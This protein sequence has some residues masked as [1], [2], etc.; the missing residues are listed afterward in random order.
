MAK[1]IG[2]IGESGSGKTTSMEG[3]DPKTTIYIDADKKG[4]SWKGWRKQYNSEAKNY[5]KT[6]IPQVIMTALWKING[7]KHPEDP[8][9]ECEPM[10]GVKTVVIDTMKD[11]GNLRATGIISPIRVGKK[12]RPSPSSASAP[13]RIWNLERSVGDFTISTVN[14]SAS[15]LEVHLPFSKV[16]CSLLIVL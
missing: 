1:V 2:I 15:S 5:I 13:N 12:L 6:D 10:K 8:N 4:L 14:P 11:L 9:K 3:L 16:R 7:G